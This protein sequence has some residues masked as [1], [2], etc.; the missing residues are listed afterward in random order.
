MKE[1]GEV[2]TLRLEQILLW[3]RSVSV[4]CFLLECRNTRCC[5]DLSCVSVLTGECEGVGE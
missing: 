2:R 3:V 1:I 5:F 4:A